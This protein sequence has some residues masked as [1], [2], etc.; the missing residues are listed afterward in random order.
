MLFWSIIICQCCCH[1][2]PLSLWYV[3]DVALKTRLIL[4]ALIAANQLATHVAFGHHAF[5]AQYDASKPVNLVGVVVKIEW[6]NPHAYFF[7]NSEDGDTGQVTRWACE[8]TSPVGL[9]RRG[10][11]RNTLQIGDI[12][13]VE[14]ALARDGGNSMNAETVILASTGRRLFSGTNAE[15]QA[16]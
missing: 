5:I 10:W 3:R 8:L 16:Q 6:L 7:I 12:V 4:C 2:R 13:T 1:G 14:G 11:T 9:M 15:L